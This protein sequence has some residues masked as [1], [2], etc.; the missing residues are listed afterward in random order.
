MLKCVRCWVEPKPGHRVV[1]REL[2]PEISDAL[3]VGA[4]GVVADGA[5]GGN[6]K[7]PVQ[8]GNL[9]VELPREAL[10]YVV[11]QPSKVSENGA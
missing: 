11:G 7:V 8:F 6:G 4:V 10:F 3:S 5:S 9:S 1:L 2:L